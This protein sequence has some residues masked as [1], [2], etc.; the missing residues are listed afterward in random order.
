MVKTT[1][2]AGPYSRARAPFILK[3]LISLLLCGNLRALKRL[4]MTVQ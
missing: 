3:Q 1:I 4:W 2:T